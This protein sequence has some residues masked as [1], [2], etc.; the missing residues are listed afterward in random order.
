MRADLIGV[1]CWALLVT[2]RQPVAV[3]QVPLPVPAVAPP[4]PPEL[5]RLQA[6]AVLL[7]GQPPELGPAPQVAGLLSNG[8]RWL[9]HFFKREGG[10]VSSR[11]ARF[12]KENKKLYAVSKTM[13]KSQNVQFVLIF[14]YF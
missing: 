12:K 3:L 6:P 9:E 14:L 1:G 10:E 2:P 11:V 7:A 8:V 13:S 4:P 5:A